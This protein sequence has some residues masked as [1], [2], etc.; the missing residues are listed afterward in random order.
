VR[1]AAGGERSTRLVSE[2]AHHQHHKHRSGGWSGRSSSARGQRPPGRR[3]GRRGR[4]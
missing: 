3:T 1:Y 4:M 2:P